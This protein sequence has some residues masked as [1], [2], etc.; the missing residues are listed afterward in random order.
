MRVFLKILLLTT[1]AHWLCEMARLLSQT[2]QLSSYLDWVQP[3][4]S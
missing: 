1:L 4:V 3:L 2:L